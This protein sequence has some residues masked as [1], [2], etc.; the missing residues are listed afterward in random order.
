M[1]L[2]C[3]NLF[4]IDRDIVVSERGFVRINEKLANLGYT[5]EEIPYYQI[6][7]LEGLLR[8]STMPIE[9]VND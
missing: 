9:R 1:Y 5:V 2:M 7:K 6:S 8:C 3:C 4:S